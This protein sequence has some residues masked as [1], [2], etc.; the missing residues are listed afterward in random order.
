MGALGLLIVNYAVTNFV[1]SKGIRFR[2]FSVSCGLI[3]NRLR[4]S[5]PFRKH[6][7]ALQGT[8]AKLYFSQRLFHG[9]V[10]DCPAF[11]A[12][13][14]FAGCCPHSVTASCY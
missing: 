8:C 11:V 10:Q 3:L 9:C 13:A 7:A 5:I 6:R 4:T 2:L 1:E 12:E 14:L